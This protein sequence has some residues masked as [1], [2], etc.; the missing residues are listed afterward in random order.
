MHNFAPPL[1]GG[2]YPASNSF[3]GTPQM[4]SSYTV[5]RPGVDAGVG[6]SFA[7]VWHGKFFAEVR[8]NRIFVGANDTVYVPATFGFRW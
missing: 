7:P 5:N 3:F 8:Y 4:L 1:V 2:T 6:I